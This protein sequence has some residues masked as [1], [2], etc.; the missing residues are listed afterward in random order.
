MPRFST[1]FGLTNAQA[2]LDFVDIDLATDTPLYLDPYAIQIRAD[3]FSESCTDHIRSFFNALLDALRED[4]DVR[5]TSLLS[6][7]R[8]PNE[9]FL[10]QSV[11]RPRG[12]AVGTHKGAELARAI[13]ESRAFETGLLSDLSEAALFI[14]GV[15]SDT[16]SDLTTNILRNLLAEYTKEQC[17]IYGIET[18]PVRNIG[19]IW[20]ITRRDWEACAL[21]L[22]I[23]HGRPI[24][25]VPKSLVRF[26]LCLDTQEFYNHHMIEF[27]RQ[28]YENSNSSLVNILKDGTRRVYKN[29][30]KERHPMIKDDLASFVRDHPEVL[31][32]YK[33]LKGAE[34]ALEIDEL[35][36]F[37]DERV[38][39]NALIERLQAIPGGNDSASEYHSVMI[40]ICTFLFHP[41][42]IIP[43][44]EQE[45]HEG[46]KRIDIKFTNAARRGF[47]AT[48]LQSPQMRSIN[49]PIECKNYTRRIANPEMDQLQGRFGH[50]RGFF[51]I[52][53]CRDMD[54]KDRI[55]AGCRDTALDGRGYMLALDDED[56]ISM[57]G[58]VRDGLRGN[59]DR[60][61]QMRLDEISG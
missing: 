53:L 24:L 17:E 23:Y 41:S 36:R 15:G 14:Y 25:L 44:K 39:A 43:V 45:I 30:V 3:E 55:R 26:R 8:E 37:F 51:G 46:R 54:N 16:I 52:L 27:L 57:L 49:V 7:L 20:N 48:V 13:R 11:G 9:T 34:G 61:L 1:A 58:F 40:G 19:P 12:R 35:E 5:A 42:L 33:E 59:I 38:F 18:R 2:E 47:F 28:E 29:A 60:Y 56:I 50:T 32:R 10:G 22:P 31:E 4:N 21:D 6:N